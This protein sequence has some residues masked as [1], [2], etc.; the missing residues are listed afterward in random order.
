MEATNTK[1]E[2]KTP[3]KETIPAGKVKMINSGITRIVPE[4][5]IDSFKK[6]GYVVMA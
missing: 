2:V 4:S 3:V 1:P 6:K 5:Q